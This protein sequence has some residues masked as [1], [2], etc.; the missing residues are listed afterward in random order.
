MGG[1]S[2]EVWSGADRGSDSVGSESRQGRGARAKVFFFITFAQ[3]RTR[4][5]LCRNQPA[6]NRA[7]NEVR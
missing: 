7:E 4:N 5:V 2:R 1:Q 3:R 6:A